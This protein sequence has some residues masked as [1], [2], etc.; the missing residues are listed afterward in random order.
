MVIAGVLEF[1]LGNTFPFVVSCGF[2]MCPL[3]LLRMALVDR[4][5]LNRRLLVHHGSD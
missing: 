1:L 4:S 3:C 5:F 2:G